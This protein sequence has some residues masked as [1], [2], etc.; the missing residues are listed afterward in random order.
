MFK[1]QDPLEEEFKLSVNVCDQSTSKCKLLL[2]VNRIPAKL[3]L[4]SLASSK[5]DVSMQ[6]LVQSPRVSGAKQMYMEETALS[7]TCFN[8]FFLFVSTL[9]IFR[10]RMKFKIYSY[11]I[12]AGHKRSFLGLIIF[13][14]NGKIEMPL[15][16]A[17]NLG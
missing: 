3:Q 6:F 10:A 4:S 11:S 15:L 13:F 7:L 8:A 1:K 5:N 9:G 16:I 2:L 12:S 14:P 17:K